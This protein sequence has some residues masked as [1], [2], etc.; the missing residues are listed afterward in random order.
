MD[1]YIQTIALMKEIFGKDCQFAL[2]TSNGTYPS[3][4]YIDAYFDGEC[5][6]LITRL[7]SRKAKE[8][9]ANSNVA[10]CSRKMFRLEGQAHLHGHP[11]SPVN[12]EIRK[13]LIEAFEPWYFRDND[14]N[15]AA[16]CYIKIQPVSVFFHQDGVG[17]TVDFI[18]K[19]VQKFPFSFQ[20]YLTEID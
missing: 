3:V 6:Y 14:E 1:D 5:F 9:A 18:G 13:Q 11:L 7:D 10:L 15:D 16:M 17:Y 4:R 20:P 12:R 8:I 2:A 19:S